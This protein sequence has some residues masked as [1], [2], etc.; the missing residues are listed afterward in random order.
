MRHLK[1]LTLSAIIMAACILCSCASVPIASPDYERMATNFSPPPGKASVYIYRP[2]NFVGSPFVANV[3]IDDKTV[4][5]V[6]PSTYIFGNV[7]PGRHSIKVFKSIFRAGAVSGVAK[8]DA[9][10]GKL[11]FFKIVPIDQGFEIKQVDENV[12][13]EISRYN[14]SG[15]SIFDPASIAHDLLLAMESRPSVSKVNEIKRDGRF[16]AY[17]NGTV[18]D[19]KTNLMWAAKDNGSLINWQDAKVYCEAYSGGGYMDWRMPTHDELAGL[20]DPTKRYKTS[21]GVDAHLTELIGLTDT[22]VWAS[23]TRGSDRSVFAFSDSQFLAV[24]LDSLYRPVMGRF[25]QVLPVRSG[26]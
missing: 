12:R 14:L 4:G 21:R 20:Y 7:V 10:L 26:K 11:Y 3:T 2:Y 25:A 22:M 8:L 17:D 23:E 18:L 6:A 16:I 15:D 13:N 24:L 5:S 9:E 1:E 19:T